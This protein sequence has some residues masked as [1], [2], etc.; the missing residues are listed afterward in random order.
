LA[1]DK[2]PHSKLFIQRAGAAKK[3]AKAKEKEKEAAGY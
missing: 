2:G 3:R 1:K